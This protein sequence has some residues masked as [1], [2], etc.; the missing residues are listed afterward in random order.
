MLRLEP[1]SAEEHARWVLALNAAFL[2][3]G[4]GSGGAS[5]AGQGGDR[6]LLGDQRWSPA[7]LFG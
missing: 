6:T 5:A 7:I 3:S 2:A 1:A 4:S